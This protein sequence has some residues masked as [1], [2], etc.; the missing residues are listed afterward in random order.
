MF[1]PPQKNNNKQTKKNKKKQPTKQKK[2]PKTHFRSIQC[3]C[4]CVQNVHSLDWDPGN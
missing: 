4:V 1:I 2:P 3:V